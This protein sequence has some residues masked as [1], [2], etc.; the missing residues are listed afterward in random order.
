LS[1]FNAEPSLAI[2]RI[3]A[4]IMGIRRALNAIPGG[5]EI[6]TIR[7]VGYSFRPVGN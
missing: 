1:A 2:R 3:D 4:I 7:G 5:W 6:A